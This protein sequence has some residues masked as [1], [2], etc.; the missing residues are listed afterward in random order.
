MHLIR[1]LCLAGL[2]AWL[3]GCSREPQVFQQEAFIFGTRVEISV[4]ESHEMEARAAMGEVLAE[5][6]R[7]QTMLHAW[8]P[9]ILSTL[10]LALQTGRTVQVP[11][12]LADLVT[13]A[14]QFAETSDGLF[15]PGIGSLVA[16]W[17]FHNDEFEARLPDPA[18]LAELKKSAPSI[19]ALKVEGNSITSSN[20]NVAL[21]LGGYAKGLALDKAVFV[22]KRR[23]MENALINIGGNVMALGSKGGKP[24]QV[25]IQHP[26]R[27]G[28]LAVLTLADGEAV[29]TSG[30][31]QRFFELDG[32]RYSHLIDP[33]TAEPAQG[34]QAVTVK[35]P[36]GEKTGLRSDVLS[37]PLFIAGRDG[38]LPM[39]KK[40]GVTHALRVDADGSVLAT[41]ALHAGLTPQDDVKIGKAEQP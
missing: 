31:Y 16:L 14:R 20:P 17:G 34:T 28:L 37:K 6:D 26:R 7:L 19:L 38:W 9:S 22:L 12:D 10:N 2:V 5:F 8:K 13:R 11:D 1:L 40:L 33:R 24:W 32:R 23:G 39:A 36:A 41:P 15:D 29:G 3:S 18:A 27:A 4:W 35:L 25:G 21:D 30:D